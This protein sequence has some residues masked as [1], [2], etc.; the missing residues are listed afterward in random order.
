MESQNNMAEK[1]HESIAMDS[2]YYQNLYIKNISRCL[3][4]RA[5]YFRPPVYWSNKIV[6]SLQNKFSCYGLISTCMHHYYPT[7]NKYVR[8]ST[9]KYPEMTEPLAR[10]ATIDRAAINHDQYPSRLVA[11]LR[12]L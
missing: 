7:D 5:V 1:R 9:R 12:S 2:R 3:S 4:V 10:P 6:C 8:W 11:F